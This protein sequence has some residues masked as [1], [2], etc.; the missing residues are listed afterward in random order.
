MSS[1]NLFMPRL[2]FKRRSKPDKILA[3]AKDQQLVKATS[4]VSAHS[5]P[6]EIYREILKNFSLERSRNKDYIRTLCSL[7]FVC[8]SLRNIAQSLLFQHLEPKSQRSLK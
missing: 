6:P 3:A 8:R 4:L 1:A 2:P 5:L 7:S